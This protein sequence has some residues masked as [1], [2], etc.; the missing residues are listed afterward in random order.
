M[1]YASVAIISLCTSPAVW[2]Q[3]PPAIGT[4]SETGE[5]SILDGWGIGLAAMSNQKGFQGINRDNMIIPIVTFENQYIRWFGPNLDIKLP[6]IEINDLQQLEFSLSSGYDFGGYDKGEADDTPILQGMDEREGVFAAGA[7]VEWKNPWLNVNAKWMTDISGDRDGN[8]ASLK[9]EKNWM[10]SN[11]V[12]LAPYIGAT[13]LDDNFVDYHYGVRSYEVRVDRP[14]YTGEATV[15][16]E[17]GVRAAYMFD[18]KS[19]VIVD[20]GITS[21]GSEIKNSPL[22]DSSTENN[23]LILYMYKF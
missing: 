7:Q 9:F 14:A 19:S 2:A 23:I 4:A 3:T 11:K 12:M 10:F 5:E 17:F 6:G 20:L 15:N 16:I 18:A 13:W 22:V 1:V 8:R 21:L